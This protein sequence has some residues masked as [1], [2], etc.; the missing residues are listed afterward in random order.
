MV[1][2]CMYPHSEG[3]KQLAYE[4]LEKY[5]VPV[6]PVNCLD[7]DEAQIKQILG[8]K[9]RLSGH[10]S[11]SCGRLRQFILCASPNIFVVDIR[12]YQ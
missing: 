9:L 5:R 3:S 2:N 4:M 6:V 12:Q 11:P 7:L 1:L 10:Y 8:D